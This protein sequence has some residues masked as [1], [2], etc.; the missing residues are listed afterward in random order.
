MTLIQPQRGYDCTTQSFLENAQLT[1]NPHFSIMQDQAVISLVENGIGCSVI[2]ELVLQTH[3]GNYNSYPIEGDPYRTIALA[4]QQGKTQSLT[5]KKMM[6]EIENC[7]ESLS[8]SLP[9]L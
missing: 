7:I 1:P 2:P 4:T 5:T 3:T 6:R 9:A 8:Q